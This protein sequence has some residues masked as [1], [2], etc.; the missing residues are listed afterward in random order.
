MV[1]KIHNNKSRYKL[2]LFAYFCVIFTSLWE[3]NIYTLFVFSCICWFVLP[4]KKYWDNITISLLFFSLFYT[5]MVYINGKSNSYFVLLSYM[6]APTVF[7]RFGKFL[8]DFIRQDISRQIFLICSI[9]LYL[10]Y[11]YILT[12]RDVA[13]VGLVNESRILLNN[14]SEMSFSMRGIGATMYGMMSSIGIGCISSIF[15]KKQ[16]LSLKICFI[17]ITILSMLCVIHLVN[18]TGIVVFATCIVMSLLIHSKMNPYKVFSG[19]LIIAV[20]VFIIVKTEMV[21]Q[22]IIDAYVYRESSST[23]NSSELG[24]RLDNWQGAIADMFIHPFGWTSH[25][26]NYVHN[27]WMDIARVGGI[28][29]LIPFLFATFIYIKKII[30]LSLKKYLSHFA[31]II[32]SVNIAIFLSVFVEP[33]IEA[34]LLYFCI[35]MMIWGITSNLSRENIATI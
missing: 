20:V 3:N 21:N 14:D 29:P 33:V 9:V 10:V 34:S 23:S 18:R 1:N 27:L 26:Y 19:L 28:L 30:R 13:L 4:Y 12:F 31:I 24:G 5:L 25:E 8:M 16:N 2:L 22:D 35:M 6:I 17:V 7:Y 32:I 15:I 11:L